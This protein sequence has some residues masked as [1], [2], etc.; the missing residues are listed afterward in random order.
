MTGDM[1][2]IQSHC[3]V[4]G[5]DCHI[6][7]RLVSGDLSGSHDGDEMNHTGSCRGVGSSAAETM[8]LDRCKGKDLAGGCNPEVP[9][10]R[11][12]GAEV[13]KSGNSLGGPS[14]GLQG[15]AAGEHTAAGIRKPVQRTRRDKE[16]G[17]Y[18]LGKEVGTRKDCDMGNSRNHNYP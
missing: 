13:E 4:S 12:Q 8:E 5:L 9:R 11:L 3:H 10:T 16:A 18:N 17:K 6:K 7:C 15:A 1:Q 2:R 14:E